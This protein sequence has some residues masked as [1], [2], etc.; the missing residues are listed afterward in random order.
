MFGYSSR[1]SDPAP[2]GRAA[3]VVRLRGD[4]LDG[5]DLQAGRLQGT[6]RGLPAGAGALDEH[7]DLAHA[8]LGSLARGV[9][10]GHLGGERGGLARALEADMAGG[11][12]A[13]HVAHRVGDRDDRVVEGAL[14]VRV[15]VR[16]VLLL[17][18]PDLLDGASTRLGWH[19]VR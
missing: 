11:G 1:A 6:D 7:V 18:A 4:V 2:L 15:P 3:A 17:L 5:A 14:D 8:V 10:G 9:L 19:V 16:D 13:D 12:P